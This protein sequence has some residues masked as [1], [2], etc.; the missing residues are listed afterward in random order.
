DDMSG[1]W[2]IPPAP[3]VID[4]R[5]TTGLHDLLA[6]L[7]SRCLDYLVEVS[8]NAAAAWRSGPQGL[9]HGTAYAN[10]QGTAHGGPAALPV[11]STGSAG[12][13]GL[14]G[15]DGSAGAGHCGAPRHG[16]LAELARS[17]PQ[18][19]RRLVA[20]RE[21]LRGRTMRAQFSA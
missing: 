16:T 19:E 11:G 21:P 13:V 17:A 5:S 20:W 18:P 15:A 7:D 1:D 14:A 2:G 9:P 12:A 10:P 8:G 4:A 3:A 6:E